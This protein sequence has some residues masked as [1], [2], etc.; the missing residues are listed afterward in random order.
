MDIFEVP[1]G[2]VVKI[3]TGIM[4]CGGCGEMVRDVEYFAR[5]TNEYLPDATG[6]MRRLFKYVG[7]RPMPGCHCS[8]GVWL[9][10]EENGAY[11]AGAGVFANLFMRGNS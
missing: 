10:S 1:T 11:I 3:H 5:A 8:N 6:P 2:K 9:S 7:P 4:Q